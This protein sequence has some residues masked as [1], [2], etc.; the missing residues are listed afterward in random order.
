VVLFSPK[1]AE[2]AEIFRIYIFFLP[3]RIL[4][5]SPILSALG[6]QKI[7]MFISLIDLALNFIL[8]LS[9]LKV[10]GLKGP[11]VAVVLSTYIET[12]LMLY[13]ILRTLSGIKLL[14]HFP[15]EISNFS[16]SHFAL[17]RLILLFDRKIHLRC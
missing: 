3:V 13:F 16:F 15:R 2:S 17:N 10:I 8:G 7:Y 9:L 1:Y 6:K 12:S 14:G 5:Y 4:L 11:A